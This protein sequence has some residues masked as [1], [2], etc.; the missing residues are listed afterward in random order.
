M[1][2]ALDG[3]YRFFHV[4]ERRTL[5]SQNRVNGFGSDTAAAAPYGLQPWAP[6]T[7]AWGEGVHLLPQDRAVSRASAYAWYMRV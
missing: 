2:P 5:Y 4:D 3:C 7:E 6:A 1:V